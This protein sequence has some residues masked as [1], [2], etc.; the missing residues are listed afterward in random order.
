MPPSLDMFLPPPPP[1]LVQS[2]F[3]NPGLG[4]SN[5]GNQP[6]PQTGLGFPQLGGLGPGGLPPHPFGPLGP[7]LMAPLGGSPLGGSPLGGGPLGGSPLGSGPLGGGPLGGGPIG[8]G[9][10]GGGPL[11]GAPGFQR[12]QSPPQEKPLQLNQLPGFNLFNVSK[13]FSERNS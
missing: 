12:S 9:P 3:M 2:G 7:S 11:G 13:F 10:L 8:G 6:W 1:N 4:L 5:L